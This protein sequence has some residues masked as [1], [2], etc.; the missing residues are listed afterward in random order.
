MS[1]PVP[2][3]TPEEVHEMA[4]AG[5]L[6]ELADALGEDLTRALGMTLEEW[7]A[8]P[9]CPRCKVDFKRMDAR[10]A[11]NCNPHWRAATVDPGAPVAALADLRS[12]MTSIENAD[13]LLHDGMGGGVT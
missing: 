7:Y 11:H 2:D 4:T 3:L 6:G 8:T 12:L 13:D 10:L 1:D 5:P 9:V